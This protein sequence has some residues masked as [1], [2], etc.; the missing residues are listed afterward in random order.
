MLRGRRAVVAGR[1]NAFNAWLMRVLPRRASA[2]IA[3]LVLR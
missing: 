1:M 2:W 3:A